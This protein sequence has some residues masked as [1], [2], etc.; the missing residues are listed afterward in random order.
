MRAL[1]ERVVRAEVSVA[2]VVVGRIDRGL[3]V[4]LAVEKGD[5]D[6]D[7][8]WIADKI[9]GLRI[10]PDAQ[11]KMN[12]DVLQVAGSA[13]VIPAFSLAA[14]AG[15]GR[16]PAFDNAARPDVAEP[17]YLDVCRRL[18]AAGLP[19]AAGRFRADM[20]VLAVND[21]PICILLSTR[22]ASQ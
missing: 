14:D 20:Q 17:A 1:V 5:S 13:L 12:L 8:A 22:R 18:S 10:F 3:L 11:G 9:R 4:Y 6:S 15:E 2:N 7:V 19:V 16:R 21:G